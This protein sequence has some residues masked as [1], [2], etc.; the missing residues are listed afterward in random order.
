MKQQ[1]KIF[2]KDAPMFIAQLVREGVT[3]EA[4]QDCEVKEIVVITFLGGY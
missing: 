3:F 4:H 2:I 1:V